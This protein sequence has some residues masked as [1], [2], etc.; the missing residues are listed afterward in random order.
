VVVFLAQFGL[1]K[2]LDV[3][4]VALPVARVDE[5]GQIAVL[6]FDGTLNAV[7]ADN[8]GHFPYNA[9]P[10]LQAALVIVGHF[11]DKER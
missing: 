6:Q 1:Q 3:F 9:Q 11:K 4:V 5:R 8:G 7:A 2:A 10:M